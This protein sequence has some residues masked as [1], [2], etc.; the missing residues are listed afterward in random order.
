MNPQRARKLK[1]TCDSCSASKVKCEK[2]WP[3]CSRC[4]NLGYPCFY[5]PAMRK[6]RPHPTINGNG[7][8]R[9]TA[10]AGKP[11]KQQKLT[12]DPHPT[13]SQQRSQNDGERD[14]TTKGRGALAVQQHHDQQSSMPYYPHNMSATQTQPNSSL[15]RIETLSPSTDTS[16]L[17]ALSPFTKA[18][19]V[20]STTDHDDD[21]NDAWPTRSSLSRPTMNN[22]CSDCASIAMQSLQDTTS[23]S[24]P[25]LDPN[26]THTLT[27]QFLTASTSIKHLSAILICPCSRNPD[28]GLLNAALCATILDSYCAIL[29]CA[30]D[31]VPQTNTEI[32]RMMTGSN[33]I[34]S[35][36]SIH[37]GSTPLG[38][39]PQPYSHQGLRQQQ[40]AVI[41][42]VLEELPKAANVVMQFS[43]RY[44]ST[45]EASDGSGI[46]GKEDVAGLLP[47]LAMEQRVR[48]KDIVN[49]ATG[50]MARVV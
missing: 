8:K 49:K 18:S 16:S 42:R 21:N 33:G 43:R 17:D 5:S 19:S 41:Q 11:A 46:D 7:Q 36:P 15:S 34:V 14:N 20:S 35:P 29:R 32:T 10:E 48:L 2:Q 12:S 9:T 23:A 3:K 1:E 22:N 27:N 44:S 39:A 45:G 13:V 37:P 40:Q 26:S 31:S 30:V 38:T 50:L 4:D 28:I 47:A 6:G 24:P 25:L